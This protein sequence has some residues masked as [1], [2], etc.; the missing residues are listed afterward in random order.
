MY[1]CGDDVK[2]QFDSAG[3]VSFMSRNGH[4][5]ANESRSLFELKYRSYSAENVSSFFSQYCKSNASWVAHDYGKPGLPS[6]VVGKIF[7]PQ[8][9]NLYVNTSSETS[10][11]FVIESSFDDVSSVDYGAPSQVWTTVTINNN[12]LSSMNVEIDMYV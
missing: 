3:A 8:V 2:I 5:W 9:R 1:S 7:Q 10:C 6:S 12:D 4:V 11:I